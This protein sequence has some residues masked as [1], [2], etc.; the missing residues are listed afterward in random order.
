MNVAPGRAWGQEEVSLLVD[1]GK[2]TSML[3][4]HD[5]LSGYSE[6][7]NAACH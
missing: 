7:I 2:Q 3:A 5:I 1:D 4:G 6:R